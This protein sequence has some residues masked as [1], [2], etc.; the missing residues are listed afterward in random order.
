MR[1]NIDIG[2]N[3]M[4]LERIDFCISPTVKHIR[5]RLIIKFKDYLR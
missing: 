3:G 2:N 1:T 5:L 4:H